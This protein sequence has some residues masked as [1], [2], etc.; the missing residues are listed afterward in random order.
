MLIL[1]FSMKKGKKGELRVE[2]ERSRTDSIEV[3]VTATGE[4]QPV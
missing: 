3:T 1:M 2:T 4:L